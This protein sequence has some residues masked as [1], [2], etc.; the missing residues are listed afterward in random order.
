MYV[1]DICIVHFFCGCLLQQR[2]RHQPQTCGSVFP[3]LY[4]VQVRDGRVVPDVRDGKEVAG[5]DAGSRAP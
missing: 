5:P 4:V 2:E 3:W 1:I